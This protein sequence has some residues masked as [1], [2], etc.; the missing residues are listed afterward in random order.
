MN[1]QRPKF[2]WHF[3]KRTKLAEGIVDFVDF[4]FTKMTDFVFVL[5]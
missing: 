4:S 1:S 3:K 5:K 2:F